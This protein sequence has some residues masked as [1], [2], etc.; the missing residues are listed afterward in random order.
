MQVGIEKCKGN[1]V[2]YLRDAMLIA[3]TGRLHHAIVCLE[4]ALEEFGKILLLEETM[5]KNKSDPVEVDGN[6]FCDHNKKSDRALSHLDPTEKFRVLFSPL[7]ERGMWEIGMWGETVIGDRTRLDCSFVDFI[8]N[9]WILG[10]K[11]D[12]RYLQDLISVIEQGLKG[13]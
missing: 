7:W 5:V 3:D 8:N 2:D 10:K 4:F 9:D 6:E 1:I 11:I 13:V 12:E